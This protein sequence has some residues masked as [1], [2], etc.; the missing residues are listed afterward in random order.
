MS[1]AVE[2]VWPV[3]AV[4]GE[5]PVWSANDS[6]LW[7]VDIKGHRIHAFNEATGERSSFVT[8]E[9]SAFIFRHV[10]GGMLC[11]LRSGLYRF[12]PLSGR[13][14]LLVKVVE[15]HTS[16]RLNDGYVDG[17]GR[18][19]FGTMDND[20]R[21]TAGALYRFANHRLQCMDEGY[22][23]TNG[24]TMSPDG[25]IL[26]HVDTLQR[27]VYAFDV[28][29]QGALSG[30]RIFLQV[31]EPGAYPDGPTVDSLGNVWIAMFGGW[32]VRCYSPRGTLLQSID[33]PA[34]QCT[35]VAFGGMDL[36]T[37]YITTATV[38]LSESQ[39]QHQ[40]MAGGLFRA[41]VRVAGLPA[42]EF[43]G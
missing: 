26:Y 14:E 20:E 40:P 36:K 9:Y 11:G 15:A 16:L 32:G 4:L 37:L 30:K 27:C 12:D 34:A 10:R 22:C 17:Q 6:T 33:V 41:R 1:A 7:F 5:G 21:D 38:G 35:K 28:D 24:P 3:S 2:C 31:E 42:H 23:I 39:R 8:P 29:E 43:A 25:R 19:W 13:F 18:L